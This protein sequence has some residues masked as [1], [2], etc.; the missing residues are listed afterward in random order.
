MFVGEMGINRKEYLYELVFCDLLLISRGYER[1][2]RYLWSAIRW[3][4][5]QLMTAYVGSDKLREAGIHS[6]K[7]LIKFPWD[8]EKP[9]VKMS[10]EDKAEL[11]ACIDLANAHLR[12]QRGEQ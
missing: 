12:Q 9:L 1:R 3:Q 8:K 11:Q 5:H 10:A 6:P 4:T 7:D 2:N